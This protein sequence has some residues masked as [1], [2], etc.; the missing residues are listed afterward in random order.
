MKQSQQKGN[1]ENFDFINKSLDDLLGRT[2][3]ENVEFK[4]VDD[5]PNKKRANERCK[6]Q[7]S[8]EIQQRSYRDPVKQIE[9][10]VMFNYITQILKKSSS[11]VRVT[12][13]SF[14]QLTTASRVKIR[15]HFL[16]KLTSCNSVSELNHEMAKVYT[17][18]YLFPDVDESR[19]WSDIIDVTSNRERE[20]CYP[21]NLL[22]EQGQLQP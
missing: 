8:Q 11:Y 17:S 19:F 12:N 14:R 4:L 16:R 1:N 2:Q 7:H 20:F 21:D 13:C 10:A 5:R 9:N 3:T 6:P 15:E 22:T 18:Y